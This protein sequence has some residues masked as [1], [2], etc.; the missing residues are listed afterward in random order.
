[1]CSHSISSIITTAYPTQKERPKARTN[2]QIPHPAW[3]HNSKLALIAR[4]IYTGS[5]GRTTLLVTPQGC[6][7]SRFIPIGCFILRNR[8]LSLIL[9]QNQYFEKYETNSWQC[10]S[11]SCHDA[12]AHAAIYSSIWLIWGRYFLNWLI[13]HSFYSSNGRL[14]SGSLPRNPGNEFAPGLFMVWYL[15][16]LKLIR[17]EMIRKIA[18]FGI[19]VLQ[20]WLADNVATWRTFGE[21]FH[22]QR[23]ENGLN[24]G[25]HW[26]RGEKNASL[27]Y[28]MYRVMKSEPQTSSLKEHFKRRTFDMYM[29]RPGRLW[30]HPVLFIV[31]T[32][33]SPLAHRGD[34]RYPS[35]CSF[36]L[37]LD[38]Q[39]KVVVIPWTLQSQHWRYI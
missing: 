30:E 16:P 14:K 7:M 25:N 21:H 15:G 34:C 5:L 8:Y 1:M 4:V 18:L 20:I 37:I 31:S 32:C 6:S 39:F 19:I 28:W 26:K 13:T 36:V 10:I 33:T 29:V 11:L 9:D 23:T 2:Y 3:Q 22:W 27:M 24:S 35:S 12:D 17:R 38:V